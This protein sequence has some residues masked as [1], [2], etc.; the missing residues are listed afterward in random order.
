[1]K[2]LDP[3]QLNRSWPDVRHLNAPP[4]SKRCLYSINTLSHSV[5]VV[6]LA[7]HNGRR[8]ASAKNGPNSSNLWGLLFL[9]LMQIPVILIEIPIPKANKSCRNVK[10][11]RVMNHTRGVCVCYE[12]PGCRWPGSLT[13][14]NMSKAQGVAKIFLFSKTKI[15]S[16]EYK[17]FVKYL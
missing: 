5:I 15:T 11:S 3:N 16:P 7:S 4:T 13:K 8:Y 2:Q 12:S 17:I 9:E 6:S 1:M 10:I 14:V